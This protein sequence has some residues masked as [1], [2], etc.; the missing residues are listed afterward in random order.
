M[1]AHNAA[2]T[3]TAV[4][5]CPDAERLHGAAARAWDE[6]ERLTLTIAYTRHRLPFNRSLSHSLK[7]LEAQA[8]KGASL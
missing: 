8:Q 6:S 2:C 5:L 3:C 4:T 1:T 7:T